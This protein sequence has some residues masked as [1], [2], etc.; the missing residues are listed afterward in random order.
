MMLG[1]AALGVLELSA[2]VRWGGIFL[3]ELQGVL[4]GGI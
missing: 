3:Y 2:Y 4:D 1:S